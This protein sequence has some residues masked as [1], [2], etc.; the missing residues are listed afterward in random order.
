[1]AR[2]KKKSNGE[3]AQALI[4]DKFEEHTKAIGGLTQAVSD[5]RVDM[6]KVATAAEITAKNEAKKESW[7]MKIWSIILA[8]M[9]SAAVALAF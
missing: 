4:L 9:V 1:M 8:G 7:K 5:L 6:A 2:K 3:L